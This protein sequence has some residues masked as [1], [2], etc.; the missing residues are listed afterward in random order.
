LPFRLDT[1][2]G[3]SNPNGIFEAIIYDNE[4]PV[5]GFQ[6]DNISYTIPAIS[7]HILII[8]RRPMRFLFTANIEL[9]G[10]KQSIYRMQGG[11]G[12]LILAMVQFI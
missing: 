12:Q 2:S 10:Y 5:I 6:M 3:S 7:M 9:P 11:N 1:Q 8:K 4:K